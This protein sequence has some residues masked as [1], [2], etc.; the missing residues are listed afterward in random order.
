MEGADQRPQ[1]KQLLLLGFGL[2]LAGFRLRDKQGLRAREPCQWIERAAWKARR[3]VARKGPF[4]PT[5]LDCLAHPAIVR[6]VPEG[7]HRPTGVCDRLQAE[8]LGCGYG[9]GVAARGLNHLR[10]GY[11]QGGDVLL[12][13]PYRIRFSQ[14]HSQE[15]D[16]SS[17]HGIFS[18]DRNTAM[19]P[20]K[21]TR[22]PAT[23]RVAPL[24]AHRNHPTARH[25]VLL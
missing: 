20:V 6:P 21:P 24:S 15:Q 7:L 5:P 17:L 18:L 9:A 14:S 12:F 22:R 8:P 16:R 23:F 4:I 25:R 11:R 2:C 1:G 13:S 3:G 19:S 10:G